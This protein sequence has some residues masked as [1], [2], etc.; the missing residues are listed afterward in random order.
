MTYN[1]D[2]YIKIIWSNKKKNMAKIMYISKFRYTL[3]ENALFNYT[4]LFQKLV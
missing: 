2:F 3:Y 4:Y 1:F